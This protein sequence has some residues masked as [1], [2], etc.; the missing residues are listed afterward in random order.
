MSE[1]QITQLFRDSQ[2]ATVF[3]VQLGGKPNINMCVL[4]LLTCNNFNTNIDK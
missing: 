1:A 3:N 2:M 4:L